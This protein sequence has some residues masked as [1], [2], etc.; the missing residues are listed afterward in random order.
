MTDRTDVIDTLNDL[1]ETSHDGEYGFRELA[2]RAEAPE[3]KQNFQRRADEI[4]AS[5]A[6]LEQ[7]VVANGGKPEDGGTAAGALHRGWVAVRSKL[8]TSTDLS[9]LEE[10]E[11][12]EDSALARYRK[13]SKQE[14]PAPVRALVE[15]QL[16]GV[17][18]NHDQIKLLRDRQ[19]Q[20]S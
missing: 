11:R 6:D 10:A 5:L 12:G 7:A 17:Q 14:L 8:T 16:Q 18:R 4:H 9:L 2:D 19:R 1:I 20:M 13:A 15:Q 3:L